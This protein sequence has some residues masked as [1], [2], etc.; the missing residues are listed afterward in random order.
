[1]RRFDVFEMPPVPISDRPLDVLLADPSPWACSDIERK[2]LHEYWLG[3]VR[4]KL[5]RQEV[6]QFKKLR[7]DHA[8]ALADYNEGKVEVRF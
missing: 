1:L 5:E 8:Q 4:A 7:E 6:D 2:R 3:Q